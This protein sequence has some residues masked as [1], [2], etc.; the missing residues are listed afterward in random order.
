MNSA[1]QLALAVYYAQRASREVVRIGLD[2]SAQ[3]AP[4]PDPDDVL[5]LMRLSNTN[6][7]HFD[8][9]TSGKSK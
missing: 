1:E 6:I 9:T 5:I 7:D 3:P 2:G 8:P 4:T